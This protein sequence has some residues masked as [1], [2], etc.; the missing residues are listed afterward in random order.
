VASWYDFARAI[1]RE[2]ARR[3]LTKEVEVQAC[4]SEAV[5][6]P[7]VRPAYAVLG[8]ERARAQGLTLPHWTEALTRYLDEEQERRA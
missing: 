5:P 8:L 7:A 1:V 2:G 3:G 6:R 4:A